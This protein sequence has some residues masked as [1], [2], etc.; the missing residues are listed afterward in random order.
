MKLVKA[1]AHMGLL[2]FGLTLSKVSIAQEEP[3]FWSSDVELGAVFTSGNTEQESLKVRFDTE[4]TGE[5]YTNTFHFD[6][7][8]ASEDGNDTADKFYM[9]YRLG[10]DLGNDRSL[11]GRLAYEQDEFSGFDEQYNLTVGYA[12]NLLVR[13]NLTIT[14]EAG[15]G[16]RYTELSTNEDDTEA[17][18][19]LASLLTWQVSENAVFKQFLGFEIGEELTTSRSDTSLES[20]IIG[21]LAMKLAVSVKHNSEVLPG[22]DKTDTESTVTLVYKF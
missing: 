7:Y 6:T 10:Y 9:F 21:N 22:K 5:K 1:L 20:N 19:R 15:V 11:Y 2:V 3:K 4:R 12:Q 13:D 8:Q 18:V 14:G 17:L 16:A